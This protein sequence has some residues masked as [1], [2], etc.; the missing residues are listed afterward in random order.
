MIEMKFYQVKFII[1]LFKFS[2]ASSYNTSSK[3]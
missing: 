3:K 1:C 2:L